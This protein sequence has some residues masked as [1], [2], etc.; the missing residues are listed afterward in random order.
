M[1]KVFSPS[2]EDYANRSEPYKKMIEEA[3][4]REKNLIALAEKD[5]AGVGYKKLLLCEEMIGVASYYIT[6]NNLSVEFVRTKNNDAL[7]DARKTI[8]KA[9]IYLEDIV[10]NG[11]DVSTS[12]LESK[13]ELIANTPVEKKYYLIRKLGLVIRLLIDAFGDNT[14]WRWSFVELQG[15]FAAVTKNLLDLKKATKDYFDPNS[16]DYDNTVLYIRLIRKL[17]DNSASA[18]RDRYELSTHRIDD[19]R[20]AINFLAAARRV[21]ILIGSP[22]DGEE[23]KKKAVVWN[24]KLKNDQKKGIAK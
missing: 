18:Y 21:A 9:I 8:Y 3:L 23:I 6:I 11:V 10:T 24:E 16:I 19:M 13:W 4:A 17:L 2:R 14:K 15:R 12:D 22:E 20:M 1:A 7:N 5:T